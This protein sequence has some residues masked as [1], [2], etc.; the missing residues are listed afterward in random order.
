M[1]TDGI[2][3]LCCHVYSASLHEQMEPFIA[4]SYIW[5]NQNEVN[6]I[7]VNETPFL[8]TTNLVQ[9]LQSFNGLR[10]RDPI[11]RNKPLWIDAICINQSSIPERNFQVSLVKSIYQFAETTMCWLGNVNESGA[12]DSAIQTI[13]SCAAD[14]RSSDDHLN[15][16][17][18]ISLI[19]L[20]V[21]DF[22]L[23][24]FAKS[25]QDPNSLPPEGTF[26]WPFR[27]YLSL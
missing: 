27:Y 18:D 26:P 3:K 1:S 14:I 2:S 10:K 21:Q 5:G 25:G 11:L 4:I 9:F 12:S 13:R 7:V 17:I 22:W 6:E 23:I 19:W 8:A 16:S 20:V 24:T 15:L